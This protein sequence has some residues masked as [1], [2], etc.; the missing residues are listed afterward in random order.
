MKR[1]RIPL[2]IATAI[3]SIFMLNTNVKAEEYDDALELI[4]EYDDYSSDSMYASKRLIV[5]GNITNTYGAIKD[6]EVCKNHHFLQYNTERETRNAYLKLKNTY[7]VSIDDMLD[8]ESD[9]ISFVDTGATLSNYEALYP[10]AELGSTV[11]V[12]LLGTGWN[13]NVKSDSRVMVKDNYYTYDDKGNYSGDHETLVGTLLLDSTPSNV[14][15]HSIRIQG[16]ETGTKTTTSIFDL[17]L[18]YALENDIDVVNMSFSVTS[19]KSLDVIEKDIDDLVNKGVV[20]VCSAGNDGEE[21]K[22]GSGIYQYPQGYT[23]AWCIGS[24]NKDKSVSLFSNY[25]NEMDFTSY[26]SG[27]ALSTGD[28]VSG[29]SFSAPYISSFTA[30]LKGINAYSTEQEAYDLVKGYCEDLETEGRDAYTGW[31]V[32]TYLDVTSNETCL[33]ENSHDYKLITKATP[34]CTEDSYNIYQCSKCEKIK[35]EFVQRLGHE[36]TRKAYPATC[37]EDGKFVYT[38]SRCDYKEEIVYQDKLDH[39]YKTEVLEEATCAKKGKV[40]KTCNLCGYTTEEETDY[41]PNKHNIVDKEYP[42]TCTSDGHV[43]KVCKDCGKVLYSY[44]LKSPGHIY[45]VV[46]KKQPTDKEDGYILLRC[47]V[48]GAEKTQIVKKLNVDVDITVDSEDTT[49]TEEST[50]NDKTKTSKEDTSSNDSDESSSDSESDSE[51][52]KDDPTVKK[53]YYVK[54][55]TP[56]KLKYSSKKGYLTIKGKFL[57]YTCVQVK[58]STNK[59]MLNSKV[60]T[61][62]LKGSPGKRYVKFKLKKGKTYYVQ[63]RYLEKQKG[64]KYVSK[65]WSS[66]KKVKIK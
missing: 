26:G 46:E 3:C 61:I 49:N 12:L 35:K 66:K 40:K 11:N 17:G 10:K 30:M 51:Y 13:D 32:P 56:K 2:L 18:K 53:G 55:K 34:T 33:D 58:Y 44:V 4:D 1:I 20:V 52:D 37:T 47:S 42:S 15:I 16:G 39:V 25:Y 43:D 63:T 27:I 41:N 5:D 28:T 23:Q 59:M 19:P 7:T 54:D 57:P 60:K 64:K 21:V 36:L 48:C 31:G 24:I 62:R 14:K 8:I 38:C 65:S 45:T 6:V 50:K 22:F 29:T 9:S